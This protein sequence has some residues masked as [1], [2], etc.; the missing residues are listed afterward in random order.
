MEPSTS[1]APTTTV[2]ASQVCRS[3]TVARTADPALMTS[4]TTAMFLPRE[5]AAK[6]GGDTILSR[7]QSIVRC[8]HEALGV[9]EFQVQLSSDG[10]GQQGAAN[11]GTT[12]RRNAVWRQPFGQ[13]Q[14]ETAHLVGLNQKLIEIEPQVAVMARFEFEVPFT[15]RQQRQKLV[16]HLVT[17][18]QA[19]K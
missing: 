3:A 19:V 6:T 1:S 14:G 12:D 8:L 10:L 9:V 11:Q 18:P 7:I 4:S 13:L 5:M 17:H 15:S 2:L 16:L